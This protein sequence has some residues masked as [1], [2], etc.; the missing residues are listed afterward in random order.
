MNLK[1]GGEGNSSE[2]SYRLW[3][4]NPHLRVEASE[5]AK[6][7]WR[8]PEYRQKLINS[9]SSQV[10]SDEHRQSISTHAKERWANMSQ[11]Q[12]AEVCQKISE[13]GK[14]RG[15]GWEGKK[16]SAESRAKMS[17]SAKARP[18]RGPHSAET[19]AK[20]AN[21]AKQRGMK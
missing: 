6:R 13:A 10:L 19:R 7:N 17:E 8:D 1:A 3:E 15:N 14:A 18:K 12:R 4:R 11:E 2:D 9:M 5:R 20:I 21:K 16:H